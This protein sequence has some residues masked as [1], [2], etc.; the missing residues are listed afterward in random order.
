M[1]RYCY[2]IFI[3]YLNFIA[4]DSTLMTFNSKHLCIGHNLSNLKNRGFCELKNSDYIHN[5]LG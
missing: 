4:P 2:H 3:A 5:H 1:W